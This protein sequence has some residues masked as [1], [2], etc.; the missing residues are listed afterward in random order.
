MSTKKSMTVGA[1]LHDQ[2]LGNGYTLKDVVKLLDRQIDA[3]T[4]NRIENDKR[5]DMK[6]IAVMAYG[7][8]S[9]KKK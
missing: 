5:I 7:N 2:R 6:E 8:V 1:Y 3:T 9:T 4:I